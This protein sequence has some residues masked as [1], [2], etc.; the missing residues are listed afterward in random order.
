MILYVKF[1]VGATYQL[2]LAP[3]TTVRELKS[4]VQDLSQVPAGSQ[5][6]I[7]NGK[8]GKDDVMIGHPEEI[9]RGPAGCLGLSCESN[10]VVCLLKP[11]AVG[12]MVLLRVL[13]APEPWRILPAQPQAEP[14]LVV[15][16]SDIAGKDIVSVSVD[17][18][19]DSTAC[20]EKK[21]RE[22]LPPMITAYWSSSDG[23]ISVDCIQKP[24]LK[25]T[26]T[27]DE[28]RLKAIELP[29]CLSFCVKR[30][31]S[32]GPMEVSFSQMP[33]H[34]SKLNADEYITYSCIKDSKPNRFVLPNGTLL[35][36]CTGQG[37]ADLL[38][39][40]DQQRQHRRN[41]V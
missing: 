10:E 32:D 6:I 15:A 34:F 38:H 40:E 23:L 3:T 30:P 25:E 28:A 26:M 16:G 22:K 11:A 18:D 35:Q 24:L 12:R 20:F 29:E 2:S 19:A 8:E 36:D 4:K 37:L 17:P 33:F 7:F 13:P 41:S 5:R 27:I 21:L 9:G 39:G 31:L 1:L 14:G